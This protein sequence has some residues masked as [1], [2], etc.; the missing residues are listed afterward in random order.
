MDATP[1]AAKYRRN[2]GVYFA[3]GQAIGVE[4]ILSFCPIA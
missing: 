2:A 4:N 3:S 1:L